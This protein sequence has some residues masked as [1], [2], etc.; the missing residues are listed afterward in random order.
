MGTSRCARQGLGDQ[1]RKMSQ[2]AKEEAEKPAEWPSKGHYEVRC[3]VNRPG[4]ECIRRLNRTA[5]PC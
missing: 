2:R 3:H 4:R 5:E 1:K